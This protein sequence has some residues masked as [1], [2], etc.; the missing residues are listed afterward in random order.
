VDF[1]LDSEVEPIQLRFRVDPGP[2]YRF[3]GLS[4]LEEPADT[5]YRPPAPQDLGLVAGAPA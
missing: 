3:A 2:L 5:E 1:E 4:I